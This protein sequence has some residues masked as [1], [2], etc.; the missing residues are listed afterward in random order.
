MALSEMTVRHARITGNDY[1]LGDS[2]GLTLNVTARGGKVWLFRYYWAGKQKRMSLGC[3]PQISLKDARTRRDEARALVAQGIN[4]YEHRK[5]QR[6]AVHAAKEHTFEAVFNQWVEFRRLSLKEGRQSTLSQILRIFNKDVLP[7]LGGCSIYDINR[8]DLLDLLSRIEQR[9]ALT[10]AEKCRT[11]FNQLF[12][13][14]LVKIEGLEH[15]PASDLDVVALPKPPVTHN[16]FLRMDELPA[17]MAAL[18]K[19]GGANQTRLG[20][21]LLLLTGVRTG[22]LRLAT[23][24]QF[25]LAK[26]LWVIPAEV[27]KQLQ[28]AMRKPGKQTQNV[29]PYIVPLSVQ[30]LEIVRHLLDQVVPAQRYLF[31]HRSDLSK[32]ISENTLNGALRRMGYADQLTGH[33]MRATIS[34]ALNEIGYPKVWVDAQLSHADPDKVSAA[35][36]HAEY[37]EQR[38][39]MMQDWANR[40]DLWGQGQLKAASSPLTIRLEGAASLPSLESANANAVLY[41]SGFPETTVPA[42][43]TSVSNE[44]VNAAQYSPVLP[45]PMQTEQLREPRVSDIQRQRAE[46]LAIYEA[47]S[48]LPLLI[49]AKLAGKSRDQI[50]RDIKARRLLSLSLGNRGQR[51][52]DWQ[53]DPL[54]HKLVLAALAQFPD[55]DA[56]RLYRAVCEPHE[57]LKDRS[58][59][60][61]LTPENFDVT[62]RIVCSALG[63]S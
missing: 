13:Y 21:R 22:E 26:R 10:T 56:W 49:F 9:K 39:T 41:S 1:T 45:V 17:L 47:A 2:D 25:D 30:A 61:V 42:S 38:R 12:R 51:I 53:L 43:K 52:P 29:P 35:Y 27:V 18:R 62:A 40:L 5:Q 63:S 11:W 44:P 54:R 15:N 60:D 8:H 50:N 23:P 31:A 4:P 28:L 55:V 6:L 3:Y 46:M 34:T 20:L 37:V 24:D 16:P 33:G 36:N 59:I 57:R 7:T 32:R 14:A 48:N 58:P 19:Y